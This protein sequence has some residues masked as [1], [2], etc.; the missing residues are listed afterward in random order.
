[1]KLRNSW[2][3][4]LKKGKKMSLESAPFHLLAL[5]SHLLTSFSDSFLQMLT[6]TCQQIFMKR[7]RP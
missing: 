6:N 4:M 1:M 2:I 5:S 7:L 3:Q